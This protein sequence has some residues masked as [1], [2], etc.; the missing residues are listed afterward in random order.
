MPCAITEPGG[1]PDYIKS[2]LKEIEVGNDDALKACA[3]SLRSPTTEDGCLI[4]DE[5]GKVGAFPFCWQLVSEGA[6]GDNTFYPLKMTMKQAMSLYWNSIS[7]DGSKITGACKGVGGTGCRSTDILRGGSAS[8][9]EYVRTGKK[10]KEF[11]CFHPLYFSNASSTSTATGCNYSNTADTTLQFI[12]FTTNTAGDCCFF[13][14]H[15][16]CVK[17]GNKYDFYPSLYFATGWGYGCAYNVNEEYLNFI[18]GEQNHYVASKINMNI[19]IDD[20]YAQGSAVFGNSLAANGTVNIDC[21]I[22]N[23]SKS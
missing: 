14:D 16:R 19:K 10:K 17:N 23:D 1:Y 8:A 20:K 18:V 22:I 7:L 2:I 3:C 15:G 11:V 9:F 13:A 12:F 21:T 4:V 5:D 6:V